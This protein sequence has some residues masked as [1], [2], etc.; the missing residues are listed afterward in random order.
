MEE[1]T[2]RRVA[3]KRGTRHPHPNSH[4]YRSCSTGRI[5]AAGELS[6]W[7]KKKKKKNQ[8]ENLEFKSVKTELK[9]WLEGLNSRPELTE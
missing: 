2:M 4:L 5:L 9:N 1:T 8:M 6:Q 7:L 3:A